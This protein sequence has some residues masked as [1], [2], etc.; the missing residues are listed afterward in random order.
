MQ[1]YRAAVLLLK[2]YSSVAVQDVEEF[3]FSTEQIWKMFFSFLFLHNALTLQ[4]KMALSAYPEQ[5]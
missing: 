1:S 2:I 4:Y 3:V 5:L